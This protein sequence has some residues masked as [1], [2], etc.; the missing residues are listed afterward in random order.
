MLA[1]LLVTWS[2]ALLHGVVAAEQ[3]VITALDNEQDGKPPTAVYDGGFS[4]AQTIRLRLG[5]GGAGQAGLI[6]ALADRFIQDSVASGNV[7][8]P[9]LVSWLLGDTTDTLENLVAGDIDISITYAPAAEAEMLANG[10]AVE[11]KYAFRDHFLLVGPRSNPAQLGKGDTVYK[12]FSDIV[13][14]GTNA[15]RS[16]P[17][18]FLSRFDRSATNIKESQIF[19]AIG[20]VPW[21]HT[22]SRW[23]HQFPTFPRE[24]LIAAARLEEYTLTNRDAALSAAP[25]VLAALEI[26]YEGGDDDPDDPMLNPAAALLGANARDK[27]LSLSFMEWL[28]APEGGQSVV[29]TFQRNGYII[30]SPAPS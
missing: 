16:P 23:Y 6:G 12:Q 10:V 14:A 15:S 22:H 7:S 19:I 26:Y 24:A 29:A 13:K 25:D 1:F 20:Q 17:T 9:F 18:R 3:Q 4:G 5:N 2:L 21:A 28:V 27:D 11:R 30:Y 8:E